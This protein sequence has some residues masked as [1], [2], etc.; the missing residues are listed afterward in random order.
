MARFIVEFPDDSPFFTRTNEFDGTPEHIDIVAFTRGNSIGT[1]LIQSL[2]EC[3]DD[4]P[5]HIDGDFQ[6]GT[7]VEVI[8]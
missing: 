2:Q 8:D 3:V 4:S 5:Q 1:D 6:L 7:I